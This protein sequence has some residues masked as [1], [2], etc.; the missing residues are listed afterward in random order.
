MKEQALLE[1]VL[2]PILSQPEA[3]EFNFIEGSAVVVIELK[4]HDDD[5]PL[6]TEDESQLLSALQQLLIVS[7]G[8]R[9]PSLELLNIAG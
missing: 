9:K 8:K 5:V 2:L 6:F 4:V 1:H 3:L 7:G